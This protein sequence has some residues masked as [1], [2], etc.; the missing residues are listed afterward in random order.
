MASSLRSLGFSNA[1]LL[2]QM[3]YHSRHSLSLSPAIA[4][5]ALR[6]QSSRPFSQSRAAA[7]ADDDSN[8]TRGGFGNNSAP[9][10]R[11]SP[12]QNAGPKGYT[13]RY[14]QDYQDGA[15]SASSGSARPAIDNALNKLIDRYQNRSQNTTER[16][17]E[18]YKE[19]PG[20][21]RPTIVGTIRRMDPELDERIFNE[22]SRRNV[23]APK[24]E[25]GDIVNP[26]DLANFVRPKSRNALEGD[27]FKI[28]GLNPLDAWTDAILLSDYVS[29][30]GHILPSK[31]TGNSFK[32]HRRL[33]RAIKRAR[34]ASLIGA[35][36]RAIPRL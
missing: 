11:Y 35:H 23:A 28:A 5:A 25:F 14:T 17:R 30:T 13:Q 8:A 34:A 24:L 19:A 20:T 36:H 2:S 31:E 7:A 15:S 3:S 16:H 22:A 32:T 29:E 18:E 27:K 10:R 33:S 26:Y 6:S 1:R 21:V 4:S 9:Q 12:G